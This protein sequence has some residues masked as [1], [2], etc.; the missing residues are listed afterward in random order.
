MRDNGIAVLAI[1][2]T[3]VT[4]YHILQPPPE[5]GV[6][7]EM[8]DWAPG[9]LGLAVFMVASTLVVAIMIGMAIQFVRWLK[10]LW[11]WS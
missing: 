1:S 7:A 10:G 5:L 11:D 4:A 9:W 3:L 6:T 8:F 2:G